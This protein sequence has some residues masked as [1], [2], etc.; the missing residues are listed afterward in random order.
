[1]SKHSKQKK[2]RRMH[3]AVREARRL[4]GH[5]DIESGMGFITFKNH[6]H[7]IG[8]AEIGTRMHA[9]I[10]KV[11]SGHYHIVGD[12]HIGWPLNLYPSAQL[13]ADSIVALDG[14]DVL[15]GSPFDRPVDY[16]NA[17]DRLI[18]WEKY[19]QLLD[20]AITRALGSKGQT[21]VG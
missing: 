12:A 5:V 19:K 3:R 8:P 11:M 18:M 1:M 13:G 14:G 17:E 16:G 15:Q 21:D 20:S 4:L 10:E 6:H 2:R 9:E 7:D